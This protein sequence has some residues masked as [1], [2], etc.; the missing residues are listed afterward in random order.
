MSM[1]TAKLAKDACLV[2]DACNPSG[3]LISFYEAVR[4]NNLPS[5]DPFCVMFASKMA[6]MAGQGPHD[7]ASEPVSNWHWDEVLDF[8]EATARQMRGLNTD[9]KSELRDFQTLVRNL[10]AHTGCDKPNITDS[11][12]RTCFNRADWT[13]LEGARDG[14]RRRYLGG[15]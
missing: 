4:K 7:G 2:Q 14:F 11:A 13:G 6:D 5:D 8:A 3:V 9:A 15:A 1:D 10:R 12:F